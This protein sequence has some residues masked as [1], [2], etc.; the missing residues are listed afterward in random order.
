MLSK[1]DRFNNDT[2]K[3]PLDDYKENTPNVCTYNLKSVFDE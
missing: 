3:F 1:K 2:D